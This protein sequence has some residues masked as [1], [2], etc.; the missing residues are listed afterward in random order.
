MGTH[1]IWILAEQRHGILDS[2]SFEL[3]AR[4]VGLATQERATVSAL[5]L[6]PSLPDKE[7]NRLIA[8]GADQVIAI[9]SSCFADF[10]IDLTSAAFCRVVR[11][12]R[13]DIIIAAANTFGRT[14]MPYV[15]MSLHTGLTADCTQLAMEAGTGHLLQTRPAIGGNIMATITCAQRRPQMATVRPHSC[16]PLPADTSRKG[17]IIRIPADLHDLTSA[18]T[19]ERSVADTDTLTLQDAEKIVVVGRGIKR[20]ENLNIVHAFASLI[21]AAVGASRE[22]VDRGWLPYP[23]QI[24]LSGKTVAPRLYIGLGVSGAIQHLAGMQTAETIV[25]INTDPEAQ[26]FSVAD[27]G[28][29]GDLFTVLPTLIADIKKGTR[30]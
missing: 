30:Q 27:F 16:K 21:G 20:P 23:H 14:L 17:P 5:V 15:A 4:A 6:A 24:G 12:R 26:I 29:V 25:A 13:P 19:V 18:I 11:A 8:H 22:V 9:E 3:L 1:N 10:L 7:L 28:I 2:V